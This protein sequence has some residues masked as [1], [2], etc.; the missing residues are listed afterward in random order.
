MG[1]LQNELKAFNN[2][3]RIGFVD[4]RARV[5]S[6]DRNLFVFKL[7]QLILTEMSTTKSLVQLTTGGPSSQINVPVQTLVFTL[8][9]RTV[10]TS[11]KY[12]NPF[13]WENGCILNSLRTKSMP[14]LLQVCISLVPFGF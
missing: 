8:C 1:N 9:I 14:I 7:E 5:R 4:L 2:C 10:E 12:K 11:K 13:V 6:S 3:E